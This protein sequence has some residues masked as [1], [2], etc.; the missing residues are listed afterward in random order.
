MPK[1]RKRKIKEFQSTIR[2]KIRKLELMLDKLSSSESDSSESTQD[3]SDSQESVLSA[4]SQSVQQVCQSSDLPNQQ[5]H[6]EFSIEA[7][8]GSRPQNETEEGAEIAPELAVRWES[9]LLCGLDKEVRKKLLEQWIVP[10]N[11]KSLRAP[12]LNPEVQALLSPIDLK[13]DKFIEN[14]QEI[15]GKGITAEGTALTKI[16][17][18]SNTDPSITQALVDSGKLLT[19]MFHNISLH[20][21]YQ[22]YKYFNDAVKKI[23]SQ[24]KIDTYLLGSDFTEKCKLAKTVENTAQEL[25]KNREQQPSTSR[26]LNSQRPN[27]KKRMKTEERRGGERY[28][29]YNKQTKKPAR[30]RRMKKDPQ[31]YTRNRIQRN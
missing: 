15:I 6:P 4:Q 12:S 25:I 8:L 24:Q 14:L 23:A 21:K 7:L 28:V 16:L 22:L 3:T 1:H 20:R 31:Y 17:E 30:D 10:R 26:H 9:F 27:Y 2:R 11:C 29:T 5:E 18:H 19:D 13:K